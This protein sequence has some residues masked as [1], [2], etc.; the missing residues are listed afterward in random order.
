MDRQEREELR[1]LVEEARQKNSQR[2]EEERKQFYWKVR[3]LRLRR[4]YVRK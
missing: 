3:D 2:T 1:E 4:I